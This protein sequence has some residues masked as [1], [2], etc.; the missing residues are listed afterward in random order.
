MPALVAR[1]LSTFIL[2]RDVLYK[3]FYK[4]RVVSYPLY[5]FWGSSYC[6]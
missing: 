1:L 6:V 3:Y 4:K 5:P 2:Q